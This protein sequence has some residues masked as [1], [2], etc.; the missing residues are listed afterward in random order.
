MNKTSVK[1]FDPEYF[2]RSS[3]A[4]YLESKGLGDQASVRGAYE[5]RKVTV[6]D[7][8]HDTANIANGK[9]TTKDFLMNSKRV[10][11]KANGAANIMSNTMDMTSSITLPR[12]KTVVEK[13]LAKPLYVRVQGP[14]DALQYDVDTKKLSK[15]VSGMVEAEAKQKVDKEL[16]KQKKKLEKKL[17]DQLK[18]KFKGLF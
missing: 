14:F 6:F 2:A 5:P 13:L 18:N 3:V 4:A 15:N 16:D 10:I 8:I 17:G 11:I 12:G 7:T 1:G 9:V